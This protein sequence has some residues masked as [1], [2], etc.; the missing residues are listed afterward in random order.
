MFK[1]IPWLNFLQ[2]NN[3]TI[4]NFSIC[5]S[6]GLALET[7][8]LKLFKFTLSTPLIIP[9]YL[10]TLYHR[11]S[12]TVSLEIYPLSSFDLLII[13]HNTFVELN[14]RVNHKLA[15]KSMHL[16]KSAFL[17]SVK[18]NFRKCAY[19]RRLCQKLV[20]TKTNFHISVLLY[21][22]LVSLNEVGLLNWAEI[23]SCVLTVTC[24]SDKLGV[25][26]KNRFQCKQTLKE[27]TYFLYSPKGLISIWDA[28]IRI[29]QTRVC[30]IFDD[31]G[32]QKWVFEGE[33]IF[34]RIKIYFAE[35]WKTKVV[36]TTLRLRQIH[37]QSLKEINFSNRNGSDHI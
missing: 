3:Y 22:I 2:T 36:S 31:W 17:F 5:S 37:G 34:T 25:Q 20:E 26:L 4:Y 16:I 28:K 29:S 8:A 18:W 14:S 19:V 23:K 12:N 33:A 6:E 9:N 1:P 30:A 27:P 10:V 24:G 13:D 21:L 7:S 32:R 35:F 15:T 11:S